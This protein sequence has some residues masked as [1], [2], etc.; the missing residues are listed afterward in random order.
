MTQKEEGADVRRAAAAP[1]L[2][3]A[4]SASA[5]PSPNKLYERSKYSRR[6]FCVSICTFLRVKRVK[7]EERIRAC[8]RAA[9]TLD[10]RVT[11]KKFKKKM[12]GRGIEGVPRRAHPRSTHSTHAHATP[13]DAGGVTPELYERSR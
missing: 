4:A 8:T 13:D 6:A 9:H 1:C 3:T 11:I 5:A 10:P 2:R 12:W 7:I